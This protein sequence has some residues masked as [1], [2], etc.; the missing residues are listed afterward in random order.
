MLFMKTTVSLKK[1]KQ[2]IEASGLKQK[3][4][5]AEMEISEGH[6]SDCLNGRGNLGKT[7]R[8]M[9]IQILERHAEKA[10]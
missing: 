6:L 10:A 2:M 7:A 1:L 5:A 9:L 8:K 4:L 3:A